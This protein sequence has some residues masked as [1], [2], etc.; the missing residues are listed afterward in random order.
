MYKQNTYRHKVYN[1]ME[2]TLQEV[3]DVEPMESHWMLI[4]VLEI[5]KETSVAIFITG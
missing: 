3:C 2:T 5:N 4:K 1:P